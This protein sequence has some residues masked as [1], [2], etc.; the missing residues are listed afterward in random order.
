MNILERAINLIAPHSCVGCGYT[1]SVFCQPCSLTRLATLPSRCYSCHKATIQNKTCVNC[2][3]K[4]GISRV[5]AA[6]SYEGAAKELVHRL[7]F[8][9]AKAAGGDIARIMDK[10]LPILP[11]DVVVTHLPTASSRIRMRGYDQAQ[12]IA[13]ELTKQRQL[14]YRQLLSRSGTFRQVG[15]TRQSR[16]SQLKGAFTTKGPTP[17]HVLLVDDVLTTG[18]SVESAAKEL[19]RGGAKTVDIAVFAQS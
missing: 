15:A 1:G 18:A 4:T 2:K 12:V 3:K 14:T 11:G 19:K 17:S 7:K 8:E 6:T 13:R 16:F 5:W 9:R 10:Q